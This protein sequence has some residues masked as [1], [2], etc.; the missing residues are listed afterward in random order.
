MEPN[1]NMANDLEAM[2]DEVLAN[3]SAE[4]EGTD[5]GDDLVIGMAGADV[6]YGDDE[7]D[8]ETLDSDAEGDS[9]TE[10]D[11]EDTDEGVTSDSSF[12]WATYKDQMVTLK[13]QGQEIQVPLGEAL[14]GYMRQ[15]D[16]TKKTQAN[17]EALKMAE[18]A[19]ELRKAITEDPAGT[20]KY[21]QDAYGVKGDTQHFEE[22]DP[23]L[24]P[25]LDTV[26][27]QKR[28]LAAVQAELDQVKAERILNE[29][30]AEL[31]EAQIEFPDLDPNIV[32]PVAAD[33]GLSIR[34][35]YLLTESQNILG[36]RQTARQAAAEAEK[37]AEREASKR[38]AA[39]QSVRAGAVA[40][41]TKKVMPEFDSFED[42]L[43]WNIENAK[44]VA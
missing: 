22:I 23:E 26:E 14:N 20:I 1:T 18:W 16:Y 3:A 36:K 37:V 7:D 12:D 11:S 40:G 34:E 8:S 21:L 30:K 24:K 27:A 38:K 6:E 35:A 25:I 10:E 32:L 39:K 41:T 42:M 44:T 28:Q 13:V 17:A 15:A 9:G 31:R 4:G 2:F 19:S 5:S 29:V 43:K 33:R